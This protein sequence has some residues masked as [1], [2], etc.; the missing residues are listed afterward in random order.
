MESLR[1]DT[2]TLRA[3]GSQ[4]DA[5]AANAVSGTA[6]V[7][8]CAPDV[9]SV[10]ASTRL[11]AQI[12][13]ART[14]T[15][16]ADG[17]ARQFGVLLNA[18]ATA[19]DDQETASAALLG[20][21]GVASP[22]GV[23][24]SPGV[25]ALPGGQ[26]VNTPGGATA[27]AGEVPAEPRDIAR[28]IEAGRAGLGVQAWHSA[29]ASLRLDADRLERAAELLGAA[30]SKTQQGWVSES[31]D[32]ATSRMRAL[33]GWYQGHA[34]YVRGL[35]SQAS[36]HVE[37][38]RK[39]TTEIPQ[40][41]AVIDS[42]RELRVAREANERSRGKFSAAVSRAQ[43]KLG[44]LYQASTTGFANY[45]FATS[46]TDLC[47]PTPPPGAPTDSPNAIRATG[48][49]DALVGVRRPES[50]PASAPLAPLDQGSGVGEVLSSG[51]PSWP[52]G[53]VDPVPGNPLVNAPG[54]EELPQVVP[55]IIGGVMG[56][57]GGTL[58]GLVGVG[59]NALKGMQAAAPMMN[60]LEPHP[61]GG[62]SPHGGEP[63][64][65]PESPNSTDDMKPSH[66]GG[67]AAGDTEPAGI[68]GPLAAPMGMTPTQAA[69][70]SA[71]VSASPLPESASTAS[72]AM[73]AMMPPL[74]GGPRGG[75]SGNENHKQLYQDRK[76]KVVAPPNSEPVKGRREGRG[77]SR[78]TDQGAP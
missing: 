32:A 73:G 27:P 19:Y 58:G 47:S 43:V 16:M 37:S 78:G 71:P 64:Q 18:G 77:K 30:V 65:T 20:E 68:S 22:A 14:F 5:A 54:V 21:Q 39:A 25:S 10:A 12:C 42:E 40:F 33:Q 57:L 76:L 63:S 74:M 46:M 49:G 15:A 62:S 44:Q 31:A 17:M 2:P 36:I 23:T 53:A 11:S 69:P 28:L 38:F 26:G 7:Q 4:A 61:A 59:E 9:I 34:D 52:P 72:P 56:G 45:T 35:A 75:S 50:A 66:E 41:H 51:G 1:V 3:A 24:P 29:E 48:P 8:P 60:G 67:S 6:Q 13:L 55:A 70:M